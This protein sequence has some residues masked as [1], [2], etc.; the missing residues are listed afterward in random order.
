M[1]ACQ[2]VFPLVAHF[3]G[4]VNFENVGAFTETLLSTKDYKLY[5]KFSYVLVYALSYK[6]G[7]NLPL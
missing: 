6:L 5:R 7:D 3:G 4:Y 2:V 1:Q